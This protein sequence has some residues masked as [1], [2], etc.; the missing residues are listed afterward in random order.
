MR[1]AIRRLYKRLGRRGTAL[2]LLG[3]A[4]VCFGLGYALDPGGP[5][6]AGLSL[7]ARHGGTQCWSFVWII[8]GLV[9]FT[10][11]WLRIGRDWLGF[12]TALVPPLVW[13]GAN[14]WSAVSGDFPRGFA[15]AA[16]YAFGH[17]GFI[18]WAASVPEYS[19]P[20]SVLPK[21]R[22]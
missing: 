4:K 16:W 11:A 9:T 18:L 19:M 10:C 17:V 7:L 3:T 21:G 2:A 13:G 14:L 15:I 8:C 5:T 12:Y 20:H 6:S 1:A 22:R